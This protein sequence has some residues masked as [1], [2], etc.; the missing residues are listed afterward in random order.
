MTGAWRTI[1]EYYTANARPDL[2]VGGRPPR[3]TVQRGSPFPYDNDNIR[4]GTNQRYD[5][6]STHTDAPVDGPPVPR[7]L[8]HTAWAE[9]GEDPETPDD[10]DGI[11][12]AGG[13][14]YMPS[15]FGGQLTGTT[16]GTGGDWAHAPFDDLDVDTGDAMAMDEDEPSGVD[17]IMMMIGNILTGGVDDARSG[18]H[19]DGAPTLSSVVLPGDD[20]QET[21]D[22]DQVG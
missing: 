7:D 4:T 1:L 14:P 15:K 11:D 22:E 3:A 19:I 5:R 20:D 16:P 6:T 18:N 17:A 9:D 8:R 2:T 21:W 13:M 10:D 12:E